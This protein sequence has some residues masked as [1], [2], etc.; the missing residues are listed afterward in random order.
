M[1]GGY[2]LPQ[3]QANFAAAQIAYNTAL[4]SVSY[5]IASRSLQRQ[6]LSDLKDAMDYWSNMI[7][8]LSNAR[9]R[10]TRYVVPE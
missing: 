9:R 1:A 8:I 7:A 6:T 3:A 10:G 2:T 5:S 4:G